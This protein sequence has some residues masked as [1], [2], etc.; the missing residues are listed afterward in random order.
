MLTVVLILS[1]MA[2]GILSWWRRIPNKDEPPA[3]PG[4]LPLIGH[5]HLLLG[6]SVKLWNF[7]K[8]ACLESWKAGGA[9]SF[10]IGPK[11]FYVVTDPEDFL[12]ISNTC[13]QKDHIYEFFKAWLGN[14]LATSSVP[15]WKIHRKLLNPAFSPTVLHGFLDVFNGQSRRLVKDLEVEVGKGQFDHWIYTRN[16]TLETLC[17]TVMGVDI[18]DDQKLYSEYI[19]A[20]AEIN[21]IMMERIQKFW[22]HS[23]FIYNWSAL[24]RKQDAC[25]KILHNMPYFIL[26]QRKADYQNFDKKQIEKTAKGTVYLCC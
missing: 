15:V 17:L 21:S 1:L 26:K 16:N 23:D 8:K 7:A 10:S 24:K 11:V 2:C 12:K 14:G 25:L 19:N 6:D 13:L 20:V 22:L 5:A 18:K 4:A 9:V 3:Y